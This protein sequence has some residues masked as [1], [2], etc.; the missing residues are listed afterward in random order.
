MLS[1]ARARLAIA[2]AQKNDRARARPRPRSAIAI[3]RFRGNRIAR[4]LLRAISRARPANGKENKPSEWFF[5][6]RVCECDRM[7]S[8]AIDTDR[9]VDRSRAIE[10][11]SIDSKT[12]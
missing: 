6:R 1:I 5:S 7:R 11:K 9:I 8:N 3:A 2:I 4:A 12:I 10:S